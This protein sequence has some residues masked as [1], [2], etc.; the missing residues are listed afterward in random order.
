MGLSAGIIPRVLSEL[1]PTKIRYTGIAVSYNLGFAFFGGL[2]P[3][4]SLSLIYYTDWVTTPAFY[5][6]TVSVLALVSLLVITFQQK[7]GEY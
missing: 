6:I 5:L 7:R 1:Y 4:I 2:T 3:F